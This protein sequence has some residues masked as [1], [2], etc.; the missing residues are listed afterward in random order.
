VI[1]LIEKIIKKSVEN[2][3]NKK[4]NTSSSMKRT[5]NPPSNE[6]KVNDLFK[7]YAERGKV[8]PL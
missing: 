5:D 3:Q 4:K 6:G 2:S 1:S 7:K 8:E